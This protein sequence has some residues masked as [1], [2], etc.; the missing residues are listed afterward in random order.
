[1]YQPPVGG[2]NFVLYKK[3]NGK[4]VPLKREKGLR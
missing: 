1:L 4:K 3:K 2:E